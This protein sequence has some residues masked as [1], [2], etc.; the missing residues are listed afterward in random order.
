ME[1]GT[2]LST[3]TCTEL[4]MQN[5]D[6][7]WGKENGN[8]E[9]LDTAEWGLGMRLGTELVLSAFLCSLHSSKVATELRARY[10]RVPK[11]QQC[12]AKHTM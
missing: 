5:G 3:C 6:R 2:E 10:E 11:N 4:V 9:L 12:I 7:E 8:W 1:T